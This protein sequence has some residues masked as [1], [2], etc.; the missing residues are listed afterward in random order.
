MTLKE[1]VEKHKND[2]KGYCP[3]IIDWQGEVYECPQGHLN[4]LLDLVGKREFLAEIE[5]NVSPLF[6]MILKTR[7][8]VVDYENQVYS[9]ELSMKQRY[10][11]IDLGENGLISVNLKNIHK[12]INL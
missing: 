7:A 2:E 1:F 8:V 4:A 3:C 12:N 5:Q 6:Y 9:E 10:A 11:L